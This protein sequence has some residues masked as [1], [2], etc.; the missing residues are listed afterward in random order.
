MLNTADKNEIIKKFQR[1]EGDVGS[2]EVQIALLSARIRG[3]QDHFTANKKD[4]HS[5]RGLMKMVSH[6][7][8]LLTY[9]QRE[10]KATYQKLIAELDIRG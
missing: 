8:K 7:K 1:K 2:P 6:R 10:N 4:R 5:R 9:L 3:L